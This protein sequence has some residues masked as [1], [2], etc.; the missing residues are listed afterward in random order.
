MPVE[1]DFTFWNFRA[2][3]LALLALWTFF[4]LKAMDIPEG[5]SG[6]N[7]LH[8]IVLPFHEAGHVFL[9]WAGSFMHYLGGTLGQLVMPIVLAC[10][11]IL[12]RGD[13]YGAAL[14]TWLLGYSVAD[15][16]VYMFD[17]YDPKMMLLSGYTGAESANHDFIQIFGDLN[18]L[19]SARGIGRATGAIG[20]I[21]MLA[22]LAWAGW[23]LWRQRALIQGRI[24]GKELQL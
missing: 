22:S 20:R 5:S 16:G 4:I 10:A 11:L 21:I 2:A 8:M 6:S 19:N 1:D 17:A 12:K 23:L 15:T 3:G 9:M 14:F 24:S 18:L 13:A 7:L